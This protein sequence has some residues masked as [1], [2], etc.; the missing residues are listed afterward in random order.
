MN[1]KTQ[2]KGSPIM[3]KLAAIFRRDRNTEDGVV[4]VRPA[5]FD[6]KY[7]RRHSESPEPV[8]VRNRASSGNSKNIYKTKKGKDVGSPG[9]PMWKPRVRSMMV[10]LK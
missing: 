7:E 9:G 6:D 8:G 3:Q 5:C 10:N 4:P 2:K 1:L